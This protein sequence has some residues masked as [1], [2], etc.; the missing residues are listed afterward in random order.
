[1]DESNTPDQGDALPPELAELAAVA[2]AADARTAAADPQ[3]QADAHRQAMAD[4]AAM[5][6]A[7][8][9]ASLAD[10]LAVFLTPVM[11]GIRESQP[12]TSRRLTD[13]WTRRHATLAAAVFVKRGWDI[14]KFLSPELLLGG[15]LLLTGFQLSQDAKAYARWQAEQ[16]ARAPTP[17]EPVAGNPG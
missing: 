7:S 13:E 4:Q 1:M 11:E 2:S 9:V 3:A 16:Q 5:E 17:A 6:Q 15:S 14:D 10:D 8:R 12:W